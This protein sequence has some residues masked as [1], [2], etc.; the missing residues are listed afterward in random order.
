MER[1]QRVWLRKFIRN[2]AA[3]IASKDAAALALQ[4]EFGGMEMPAFPDISAAQADALL[5]Y[6]EQQSTVAPP[7]V[8]APAQVGIDPQTIAMGRQLFVG[9]RRL[10]RGG[11]ACVS[12]HTA[13]GL[14]GLG[15]GRLGP[16]LSLSYERLGKTKGM[17]AWL[18]ATPTPI[19]SVTFKENRLTPDEAAALTTFLADVAVGGKANDNG[20]YKLLALAA[21]GT[22]VGFMV[23]GGAWKNRLRGVRERLIKRGEE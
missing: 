10:A 18:S 5:D 12:C 8:E 19:M 14:N 3:V 4:K 20:R 15:G 23:I 2:S 16:D 17:T 6:I 9:E 13:R 11:S 21:A 22:L 1:R 7:A